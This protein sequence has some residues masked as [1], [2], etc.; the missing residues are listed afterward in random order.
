[1][2]VTTP[3]CHPIQSP[4]MH[5]VLPPLERARNVLRQIHHAAPVAGAFAVHVLAWVLGTDLKRHLGFWPHLVI[6]P[7]ALDDVV[8]PVVLRRAPIKV[9]EESELA[10]MPRRKEAL[11][12]RGPVMLDLDLLPSRYGSDLWTY[13]QAS[14][15]EQGFGF[16]RRDLA[17]EV[18]ASALITGYEGALTKWMRQPMLY[19]VCLGVGVAELPS[20]AWGQDGPVTSDGAAPDS[21]TPAVFPF[22]AWNRFVDGVGTDEIGRLFRVHA[23]EIAVSAA[24][25]IEHPPEHPPLRE[26]AACSAM[27]NVAAHRTALSLLDRFLALPEWHHSRTIN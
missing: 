1:M 26:N 9:L 8:L 13:I 25:L 6:A 5:H 11:A 21:Q 20:L 2:I 22:A 18:R 16:M 19:A 12:A 17:Q 7:E 14:H 23:D 24:T 10:T 15:Q 27:R 3:A 4:A